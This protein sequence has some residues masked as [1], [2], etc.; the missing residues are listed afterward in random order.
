VGSADYPIT[1]YGA[2]N[3]IAVWVGLSAVCGSDN[4][5]YCARRGQPRH[6][7]RSRPCGRLQHE[8]P[9][10][11]VRRGHSRVRRGQPSTVRSV[12]PIAVCDAG[13][14]PR[15]TPIRDGGAR[16]CIAIP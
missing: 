3:P 11:R 14:N 1:V 13:F 16:F 15:N 9:R 2:G 8:Q 10:S 4:P 5:R 7:V 6:R 12:D